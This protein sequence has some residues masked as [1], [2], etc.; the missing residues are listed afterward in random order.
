MD[1]KS[2]CI[3]LVQLMHKEK[4]ISK[5]NKKRIRKHLKSLTLNTQIP[6]PNSNEP[7]RHVV[8]KV[9]KVEPKPQPSRRDGDD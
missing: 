7:K 2:T 8:A 6:I 1:V 3:D 4:E 5:E 9:P